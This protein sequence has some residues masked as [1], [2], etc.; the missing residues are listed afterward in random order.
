MA[1]VGVKERISVEAAA[2][3]QQV[4]V[5]DEEGE[6]GTPGDEQYPGEGDRDGEQHQWELRPRRPQ[7]GGLHDQPVARQTRAGPPPASWTSQGCEERSGRMRR[8]C[9]RPRGSA[10]SET[11][12]DSD[13]NRRRAARVLPVRAVTRRPPAGRA[14]TAGRRATS[15]VPQS[16]PAV[17]GAGAKPTLRARAETR[18]AAAR[19]DS[20]AV[21]SS[22]A[23]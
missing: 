10:P 6:V 8:S 3:E 15:T 18:S 17:P 14:I 22:A 11:G 13:E 5:V 9:S 23:E 19:P 2:V 21:G 20:G 4:P 16:L 7:P 12:K 1:G